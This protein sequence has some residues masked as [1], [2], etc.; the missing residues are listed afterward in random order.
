LTRVAGWLI[1]RPKIP[2]WV[3]EALGIEN[4]GIFYGHLV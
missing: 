1:E 4:V 2:N 3:L